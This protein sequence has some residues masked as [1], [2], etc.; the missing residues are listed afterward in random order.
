MAPSG[1]VVIFQVH[2]QMTIA[3]DRKLGPDSLKADG[4]HMQRI[5]ER[6]CYSK[7]APGEAA[8]QHFVHRH[9]LNRRWLSVEICVQVLEEN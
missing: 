8:L 5:V 7:N 2:F 6:S 9:E 1:S 3:D 4:R